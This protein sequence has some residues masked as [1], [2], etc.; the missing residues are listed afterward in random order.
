MPVA[1]DCGPIVWI[2]IFTSLGFIFDRNI[3]VADWLKR[4]V[5][6]LLRLLSKASGQGPL[7]RTPSGQFGVATVARQARIPLHA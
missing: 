2:S 1:L 7:R 6:R 5:E 4:L 3:G